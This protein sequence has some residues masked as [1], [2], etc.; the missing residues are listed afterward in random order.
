M[1]PTIDRPPSTR[2]RTLPALYT[3]LALTVF[4]T[5]APFADRATTQVLAGHIRAG[6]PTYTA[7]DVDI[8]ATTYVVHLS[9][10]GALGVLGWLWTIRAV[11]AGRRW[12]RGLAT[13]LFAIGTSIALFDLL[14]VDTSGD[15]GLPP[16]LGWVGM[17]P[18]VAGLLAV[19]TLWRRT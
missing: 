7:A 6:Y 12:A 16:L 8:A 4:A 15:T 11:T 13:A 5:V 2:D 1:N 3:G 10:V 19:A 14:V 18:S 17:A 9:V